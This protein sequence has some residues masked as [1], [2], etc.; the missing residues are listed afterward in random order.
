MV[1]VPLVVGRTGDAMVEIY[2][3]SRFVTRSSISAETDPYF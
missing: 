1:G 3:L 2:S